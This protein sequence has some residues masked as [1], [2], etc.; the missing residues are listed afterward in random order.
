MMVLVAK[1]IEINNDLLFGDL[2]ELSK[3]FCNLKLEFVSVSDE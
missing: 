1:E 3:A 2:C